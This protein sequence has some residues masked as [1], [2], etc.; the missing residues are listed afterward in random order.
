VVQIHP[1]AP[2]LTSIVAMC[3]PSK[4]ASRV[5]FPGEALRKVMMDIG[6]YLHDEVQS[7]PAQDRIYA[8]WSMSHDWFERIADYMV[9]LDQ[10]PWMGQSMYGYPIKV[11]DDADIPVLVLD[12]G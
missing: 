9:T 11:E 10:A 12:N 2:R 4:Q 5:Q 6:S 8:H 7:I 1:G 3:L